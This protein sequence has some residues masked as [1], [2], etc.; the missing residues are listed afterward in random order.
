MAGVSTSAMAVNG[1]LN[2]AYN[3]RRKFV[4]GSTCITY[5]L[6]LN[7]D[8]GHGLAGHTNGKFAD[9]SSPIGL[10]YKLIIV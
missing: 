7:V 8:S 6:G 3:R 2:A 9:W 5:Y 1:L 4:E 10:I